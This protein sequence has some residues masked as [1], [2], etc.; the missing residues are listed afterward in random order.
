[1]GCAE[2]TGFSA[3]VRVVLF[4]P[5]SQSRSLLY[6]VMSAARRLYFFHFLYVYSTYTDMHERQHFCIPSQC[7][8]DLMALLRLY[9]GS[10]EERSASVFLGTAMESIMNC[11]T[12]Y[13]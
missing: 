1:M 5:F 11:M 13:G 3:F 9:H 4:L 7:E 10:F 8:C 2:L 6:P 12:R